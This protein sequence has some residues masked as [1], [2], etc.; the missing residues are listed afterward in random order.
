MADSPLAAQAEWLSR[1]RYGL[2]LSEQGTV[3]S[4]GDGI[5]WISGLPSARMDE[6]VRLEDGSSALVFHLARDKVG[7]ILL[8][9]TERLTAGTPAYLSGKRLSIGVGD[10]L[11]GRVI[12]PLGVPLDGAG[13]ISS[14]G[15]RLLDVRSPPIIVRD[16]VKQ[17]MYTGNKIIDTLI[18]IGKGQRQLII[19]D[20]GSG[21]SALAVDTVIN[22][23]GKNVYCVYVLIGQKRSS[24]VNTI[25][26][27]RRAGALSYTSVVVA[28][29]TAVPGL[30]YLAPFA[31]CTVAEAWMAEGRDSLV[32]YDDLTTHA[33][34]YRELSLLLRRPPGREAYPG[35][36]FYLH[37]RLLERSTRLSAK[38]GGGSMTALPIIETEQGEIA[39]Y[40]PTNLVSI[41]DGQVYFDRQLFARGFLPAI[42]VTRSVSRIGGNAQHP[43]I[44]KEAGRMRL[45]YL[46]F[47]ELEVF[48]RFGSKL[49]ASMETRIRRG[50]VLRE[51]LKQDL[52]EPLPIEFQMAWLVAY[53][54]GLFDNVELKQV[55]QRLALLQRQVE[56]AGLSIEEGRDQW[57]SLVHA[58]MRESVT[59]EAA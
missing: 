53:N 38:H 56:R 55:K 23:R 20:N 40:I 1:Y 12:D 3:G 35:D 11:L 28:E 47:L 45:D 8:H 54:E 41:T 58:W 34:S 31:G 19:G 33:R 25:E 49:E 5:V 57:K 4:V 32:I 36:I 22:Q 14:S 50:Q 44:K 37:A 52:L 43:N 29:A 13:P 21:K 48:T 59:S 24:V 7:A 6:I 51:M 26:T 39:S 15:S 17:P 30:K 10:G 27:L 2:R 9:Q 42:D 18:P 46:Q 16:F